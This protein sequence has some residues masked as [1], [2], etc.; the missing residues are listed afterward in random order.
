MVNMADIMVA[1]KH[2][3]KS[4]VDDAGT[5]DVLKETS[6]VIN[7]GEMVSLVGISGAGKTTLLQILG[8]LDRPTSGFARVGGIQLDRVSSGDLADFRN[9]QIGFVFQFHHLLPDFT[10]LENIT[11]PGLISGKGHQECRKRAVELLEILGLK[12]RKSH[13]PSELSGGERQRVA[14]A[15]ALFNDP[16]LVLADEPTGNLDRANGELLLE[17][18]KKANK[19]LNQTF[20]IATHNNQLAEGME[21][22]LYIEDG[23]VKD[24]VPSAKKHC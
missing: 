14:L 22:T 10:A 24:S 11:I 4:F 19:E 13:Y 20:L 1:V 17:L 16:T 3:R 21:R 5:F 15:R 9:R 7:K 23:I 18:F 6:F 8:G 2:L 12:G